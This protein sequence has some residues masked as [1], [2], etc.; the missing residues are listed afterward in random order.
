MFGTRRD[1][2]LSARVGE[3]ESDD[4]EVVALGSTRRKDHVAGAGAEKLGNARAGVGQSQCGPLAKLVG[5]RR[6]AKFIGQE[7]PGRVQGGRVHGRRGGIVE[8]DRGHGVS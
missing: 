5:A 7:R 6:V 8:I 3:C 4:G 2:V 1:K